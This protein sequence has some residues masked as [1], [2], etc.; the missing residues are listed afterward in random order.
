MKEV[1][2]IDEL[3]LAEIEEQFEAGFWFKFKRIVKELLMIPYLRF[4]LKST[5]ATFSNRNIFLNHNY[6]N[7]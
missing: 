5:T 7:L 2:I 1:Y 4:Y 6:L 3:E